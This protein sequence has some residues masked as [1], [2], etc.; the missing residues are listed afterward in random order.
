MLSDDMRVCVVRS[1]IGLVLGSLIGLFAS[2]MWCR[3]AS[4]FGA[5]VS[6]S[7]VLRANGGIICAMVAVD[8]SAACKCHVVADSLIHDKTYLTSDNEEWCDPNFKL[9]ND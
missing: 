8:N 3:D 1:I 9:P 4:F 7:Y 2:W 6:G 5:K